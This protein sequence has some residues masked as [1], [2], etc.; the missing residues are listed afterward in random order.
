MS[1]TSQVN[2]ASAL[3]A[4]LTLS[5]GTNTGTRTDAESLGRL[6]THLAE[7]TKALSNALAE[8]RYEDSK[9]QNGRPTRRKV[10]V[11]PLQIEGNFTAETGQALTFTLCAPE[12]QAG[13]LP[14]VLENQLPLDDFPEDTIESQALR[15]IM[16]VLTRASEEDQPDTDDLLDSLETASVR[17]YVRRAVAITQ[18]NDW[19]ISGTMRQPHREDE[20]ITFTGRGRTHLAE[21]LKAD[22]IGKYQAR[23]RGT[24]DG[25]KNSNNTIYFRP[26]N[27][28][29]SWSMAAATDLLY[30]EAARIS[31]DLQN[32]VDLTIEFEPKIDRQGNPTERVIRRIIA[33]HEVEKVQ[34]DPLF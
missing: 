22:R 21:A 9:D 6:I 34:M 27:L 26:K 24:I 20:P 8:N 23:L 1:N 2:Q 30:A 29:A 33:L 11:H 4:D 3:T 5:G 16:R 7:A 17:E 13:A 14:G 25:H 12:P 10:R 18:H 19:N 31:L 15:T 32:Q 28:A